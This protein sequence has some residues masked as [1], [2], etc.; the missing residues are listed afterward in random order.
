MLG[1]FVLMF[2]G[3]GNAQSA[4]LSDLLSGGS[5]TSGGLLFN[6]WSNSSYASGD[7]R[8][9]DPLNINV[10]ALADNGTNGAGILFTILNNEMSVTGNNSYNYVDLTLGFN[11]STIDPGMGLIGNTLSYPISPP[12]SK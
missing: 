7:G 1:A 3:L 8:T 6:N 5:I 9:F 11:V 2:V 12:A 10:T 4:S